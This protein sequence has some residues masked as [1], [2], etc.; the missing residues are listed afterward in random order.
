MIGLSQ[1]QESINQHPSTRS[2]SVRQIATAALMLMIAGLSG[3]AFAEN[4]LNNIS[5]RGLVQLG[6]EVMIGGLIISGTEDKTV[7]VRARGP[8]LGDAGVTGFMLD[9][10]VQLF[11][12]ATMIDQ[13][14][15]WGDHLQAGSIPSGLAPTNASESAIMITL[16]PGAY[17][18][19]VRGV[20]ETTGVA[21]VEVFE[22]D[23]TSRLQNLST[24]GF[25]STGDNVMI[26]GL[27]IGGT[28]PK[29][30]AIRARGP[31]LGDAGV[32]DTLANPQV[33]LFSGATQID[34]NDNYADHSRASE[35][36]SALVPTNSSESV[37]I[38]TLDP[39]AYTAIVS[40]ADGG[41]GIGI[42]E[43]F[44]IDEP[45][46]S[47][48]SVV[49]MSGDVATF[50]D[51][52]GSE[53]T[54]A[55]LAR[56]AS[57]H[58]NEFSQDDMQG[59]QAL[60]SLY[61]LSDVNKSM[62]V[63]TVRTDGDGN[64][65]V[66]AE[67][68]RDYLFEK[69]LIAEDATEDAIVTA[70]RA[71]GQLQV[72]ALILRENADG[73]VKAL[74]IQSIADPTSDE[75]VRV[76]PIIHRIV[77]TV[78]D[79]IKTAI[80]TLTELG[81]DEEI[82]DMLAQDVIA[83]VAPEI[84]RVLEE[85][86]DS[87]I[88][89]PDGQTADDIFEELATDF[90]VDVDEAELT[91]LRAVLES[92]EELT[93]E[94]LDGLGTDVLAAAEVK[95][96]QDLSGDLKGEEAGLV[97]AFDASIN[98][99]LLE[100]VDALGGDDFQSVEAADAAD[101][102]KLAL[103]RKNLQ[104]FFL[105][106]G[107]SVVVAQNEAE[108]TTVIATALPSPPHIPP[109]L[110]PGKRAFDERGLRY[111]KIGA[112]TITGDYADALT[113][114]DEIATK[115]DG[116]TQASLEEILSRAQTEEDFVLLDRLRL[117]E[118]LLRR[119]E[120]NPIISDE[121]TTFIL[122]NADATIPVKKIAAVV[123]DNF[124]WV[125]ELVNVTHEGFPI[126]TG[127]VLPVSGNSQ[128]DATQIA[129]FLSFRLADTPGA[130]AR[131]LTSDVRFFSQFAPQAI[132]IALQELLADG[133]ESRPFEEIL[134]EVYPDT[135]DG[136]RTL[137]LGDRALGIPPSPPYAEAQDRVSRGLTSAFPDELFGTVITPETAFDVRPAFFL[138]NYLLRNTFAI[139]TEE[140]FFTEAMISGESRLRPNFENM[141]RLEAADNLTVASFFAQLLDISEVEESEAFL[142]AV[143]QI[144]R[145]LDS[146]PKLP[147]FQEQNLDDFDD[148]LGAVVD[149]VSASC[150]V[151]RFDGLDSRDPFG[152]GGTQNAMT[153]KVFPVEFD[154][155]T[156]QFFKGDE[157]ARATGGVVEEVD[158]RTLVTY[159]VD[160][161]PALVD[162][163][164][165]REFVMQFDIPSYQNPVPELYFYVDGFI[166]H[167]DL[168]GIDYPWFVGP[169]ENFI[170]VPGIGLVSGQTRFDPDGNE[171]PEG[172]DLSNMEVPGGL[173]YLTP[174]EVER[175][176]GEIDFALI[177]TTTGF[178]L[179]AF[180]TDSGVGFAPLYGEFGADGVHVSLV[181]GDNNEP[182]F[183]IYSVLGANV[184]GAVAEAKEDST[185]LDSE[186]AVSYP[187]PDK[188]EYDRLY[189]MRD[190]QGRF[191]II[192]L[193]F[194]DFFDNDD[195]SVGADGSVEAFMDLGFASVSATGD[196]KLSEPQFDAGF[197]DEHIDL[198]YFFVGIGDW[199]ILSPPTGYDGPDWL[200]P[201]IFAF[202]DTDYSSLR[203]AHDGVAI[204]YAGDFF[205]DN[206]ASIEDYDRLF[207]QG[208]FGDVPVRI[209]AATDNVT[210]VKLS[211]Q[212]EQGRYVMSPAPA[213]ATPSARNLKHGDILAIFDENSPNGGPSWLARVLRHS[214]PDDP[215]ANFGVSLEVVPFRPEAGD[216]SAEVACF[217]DENTCPDN[218]PALFFGADLD[219]QQGVIFDRD[220][221]GVPGVFDENDHDANVPGSGGPGGGGGPNPGCCFDE[222]LHF[223]PIVEALD[224]VPT[225]ILLARTSGV[226]P[227][228]IEEISVRSLDLFGDE[229]SHTLLTCAARDLLGDGTVGTSLPG[230]TS[231]DGESCEAGDDVAGVLIETGTQTFDAVEV[232]LILP[233]EIADNTPRAFLEYEIT[234]RQLLDLD[235]LPFLCGDEACDPRPPVRGE[236]L[237]P[238]VNAASVE[239]FS[240]ASIASG[241]EA[242]SPIGQV[243]SV[244][245]SRDL[246]ITASAIT[247][248]EEYSLELFCP[249]GDDFLQFDESL[250]FYAPGRDS[251][252]RPVSPQF[253]ISIQHLGGRTCSMD[254]VAYLTND[255]GEFVGKVVQAFD[256]LIF[257]GGGGGLF[258]DNELSLI[259]G[260]TV[261]QVDG[262]VST[263]NCTTDNTLFFL[264][265][266][267]LASEGPLSA[268][269]ILGDNVDRA[270]FEA[271]T[272]DLTG[273]RVEDG[274]TVAFDF[275]PNEPNRAPTCGAIS[276]DEFS[277]FCPADVQPFDVLVRNGD[278]LVLTTA[279]AGELS[280]QGDFD[281]VVSLTEFGYYEIV[282]LDGVALVEFGVDPFDGEVY[283]FARPSAQGRGFDSEFDTNRIMSISSPGFLFVQLAGV[284]QPVD[285][286]VLNVRTTGVKLAWFLPPPRRDL[287]GNHDLDGDGVP[288]VSIFEEDGS[289]VFAFNE[290]LVARHF[291][292]ETGALDDVTGPVVV[293]PGDVYVEFEVDIAG[294]TWVLSV[295]GLDDQPHVEFFELDVPT[296]TTV[297]SGG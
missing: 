210:F 90:E 297:A 64:Y 172:I 153:V 38:A 191:W 115:L 78:L 28:T 99:K 199:V 18:A 239:L 247:G 180:D 101:G 43:I 215:S 290:L 287:L 35:I 69:S 168:C 54:T 265:G 159:Q 143:G 97:A 268:L 88:Q 120:S 57:T 188:F 244:D 238:L 49:A 136:Y 284:D 17:T 262:I 169:D 221:D 86:G 171:M 270:F 72:R 39:G 194:V 56:R 102:S 212:K 60:V 226:Y 61:L 162:A 144:D 257:T 176:E 24:R 79:Q 117:Y 148:Y 192:E 47:S 11:S 132:E 81:I 110:L 253:E 236:A 264:E 250:T 33:Q 67:D 92:E 280:I 109:E 179:S 263:E 119:V 22:I 51:G 116:V 164:R 125:Q 166:D 74:A 84:I 245:V 80:E 282:N 82:V 228:D 206:V 294:S 15:N 163:E 140:G 269:L 175:G 89:I 285:F 160:D 177:E 71:L 190:A 227:G 275:S 87:I 293:S 85:A 16:A 225:N 195:G 135:V 41:T 224:G 66:T 230:L 161:L 202:G 93:E 207:A 106:M 73:T 222:G 113:L 30:V 167:L 254:L 100:E 1:R 19:I 65:E 198:R 147:E 59:A 122:E 83:Q 205:E 271:P 261:C 77:K 75:P 185:L 266:V 223:E 26:G 241:N 40:G 8:S 200:P 214:A 246:K 91:S 126:F 46:T 152:D 55:A 7:L 96:E 25:V 232:E 6:D 235:G 260:D 114:P 165:G 42:V 103:R 289:F 68:V 118:E 291:N 220:A 155:R 32:P 94:V 203:T 133:I 252:G 281:G 237:I 209:D 134:A 170:P 182:L 243:S 296:T 218:L 128:V 111:F 21:I 286:A 105:S 37:I 10:Y 258:G 145:L 229:E 31:S 76:N 98:D 58:T 248:A 158:G 283:L 12:G 108:A 276:S 156:G 256:D 278:S 146:L 104:R 151:E 231:L 174:A 142:V 208:D 219:T 240:N 193:R 242:A 124:T 70:F 5:T 4:R 181:P 154:D 9:P 249:A 184:R 234:F 186:I 211:F 149:T 251:Q 20:G 131:A 53:P 141:K 274:A 279:F 62:P 127:T 196:V 52:T 27:I 48:E 292:F 137:I 130:A 139:G 217:F 197:G 178:S 216:E 204:R 121:L 2:A 138:V 112:G 295:M 44:E 45:V 123:A 277:N 157:V 150:T 129:R 183:G 63:A 173:V 3:H 273:G 272:Q 34:F 187:N 288:D 107:Y 233:A 14:D 36:P 201:E 13:N 259:P 189:L 50:P 213:D 267:P 95:Q 29:T 23:E 255:A